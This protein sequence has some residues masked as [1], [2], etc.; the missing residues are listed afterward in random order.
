VQLHYQIGLQG[1][2]DL[3]VAPDP[4]AGFEMTLLRMLAFQPAGGEG[5]GPTPTKGAPDRQGTVTSPRAAAG[6]A[7]P[8]PTPTPVA[9]AAAPV[10]APE[11]FDWPALA[12][13]LPVTGFTRELALNARLA[14]YT[15]STLALALP[16]DQ[17]QLASARALQGL[18]AALGAVL[19]EG[20]SLTVDTV[21]AAALP[22]GESAHERRRREQAARIE[23]ARSRMAAHPFVQEFEALFAVR[24]E[25]IH[26]EEP[27]RAAQPVQQQRPAGPVSSV[28]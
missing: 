15:G 19:G 4:R 13:T 11:G 25:D 1:R 27:A 28:A 23:A 10:E 18:A 24:P 2:R 21:E 20:L 3:A 6:P 9:L 26:L 5:G 16:Q 8:T 17:A 7:A 14:R 12:T 22:A